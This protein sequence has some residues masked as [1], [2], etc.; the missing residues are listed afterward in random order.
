[1]PMDAATTGTI[2][3]S[4]LDVDSYSSVIFRADITP[5]RNG[6]RRCNGDDI[7][8]DIEVVVDSST[9]TFTARI[10]DACPSE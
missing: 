8:T 10:Y 5:Y 2:T 1:M 9:D 4:N 7:G 6:E 3:L